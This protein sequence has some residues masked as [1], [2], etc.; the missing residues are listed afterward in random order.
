MIK[1]TKQY[2]LPSFDEVMSDEPKSK[3]KLPSFDEVMGAGEKKSKVGGNVSVA[4]SGTTAT[5]TSGGDFPLLYNRKVKTESLPATALSAHQQSNKNDTVIPKINPL[6]PLTDKDA[7]QEAFNQVN[8]AI[9]NAKTDDPLKEALES[10]G[11]D[12]GSG[13]IKIFA[14]KLKLLN[15]AFQS[16]DDSKN[17]LNKVFQIDPFNNSVDNVPIEEL[18]AMAGDNQTKQAAVKRLEQHRDVQDALHGRTLDEASLIYAA[19]SDP[20]V[21]YLLDKAGGVGGTT[22]STSA[23]PLSVRGEKKL[24]FL[25][26]PDVREMAM[27]DPDL[28]M[29]YQNEIANFPS[30]HPEFATKL[31]A[32]AIA[33]RREETGGNNWFANVVGK[34]NTDK[35]VDELIAEGQFPANYKLLY[36][37]A[38]RPKLGTA[39]AIGRGIGN[40]IPGLN[41]VV[42]EGQIPTPGLLEHFEQGAEN[43]QRGGASS[44]SH[45]L[46]ITDKL[47]PEAQQIWNT[48]EK[49]YSTPELETKNLLHKGSAAAGDLL[50]FVTGLVGGTSALNA[51]KLLNPQVA[52]ATAMVLATHGDSNERAKVLFPGE[53]LKQ[54]VYTGVMDILN[55]VMGKYLPG[56]QISRLL[57]GS[58]NVIA[59]T[60]AKMVDGKITT[61]AAKTVI[62]NLVA[63]TAKGSLKGGEFMGTIAGIDDLLTQTLQGKGIDFSQ[64]LEKGWDAFK[65]GLL[66]TGPLSAMEAGLKSNK[67]F[68]NEILSMADR[69]DYYKELANRE[70][71]TNPD[72]AKIKDDV[73]ENI[74]FVSKVKSEVIEKD[75]TDNKK[76]DYI[77]N[78]L[79]EKVKLAKAEAATDPTIK[80]QLQ[81]EAK[82]LHEIKEGALRGIDEGKIKENQAIREVKEMYNEGYL[83]KGATEMLES[84]E[85]ENGKP[86]FN[87]QKVSKFLEFVAQQTNNITEDGKFNK[88]SDARKA[89]AKQY[90]SQIIELA[91][92]MFPEYSK[93]AKEADLV[94]DI[95]LPP[96]PEGYNIVDEPVKP[97]SK[98]HVPAIE[99]DDKNNSYNIPSD[100]EIEKDLD[101]VDKETQGEYGDIV[102]AKGLLEKAL[103]AKSTG[104]SS[105][106]K[107]VINGKT[108]TIRISDHEG[109]DPDIY[110]NNPTAANIPRT[111]DMIDIILD[112]KERDY[113]DEDDFLASNNKY[114]RIHVSVPEFEDVNH[115]KRFIESVINRINEDQEFI[116]E[117]KKTNETKQTTELPKQTE[118][119]TAN[120]GTP[121][122]AIPTTGKGAREGEEMRLSHAD[123]K[124][125]YNELNLPERLETPNKKDADLIS[126]AD[127][128]VKDGYD[129]DKAAEQI[130]S[131]EK[132]SFTDEEQVAFAKVVAA[133]KAKQEGLDV[134]SP[135]F[136]VLQDKIEKYS[137]ASDVS[138]TQLGRD[139]RARQAFVPKE[140]SLSDYVM[141]EKEAAGVETLTEQQKE[142]AQKEY[143][144]ISAAKKAYEE[145][146]Q[147]LHDENARLRAEAEVKRSK[148]T[149]KKDTK[150]DYKKEREEIFTSIKDKLRAARGDTSATIVP[151]AK[152]LF[153]I[154][155]D[156]AKLVK[157]FAEQGITE[158]TQVVKNVHDILKDEINGIT[159]KDVVDLIAGEYN[160]KKKP[161]SQLAAT[162]K[163]LRDEAK[164][165]G[166][167]KALLAGEEPKNERKKI[168]RNRE[169]TELRAAIKS[170]RAMQKEGEQFHPEEKTENGK[171][172]DALK[173][174][175]EKD[176]DK[177]EEQLRTGDFSEK[178]PKPLTLDKEAKEL[179]D[180]LIKLKHERQERLLKEEYAKSSFWNKAQNE[181]ANI[182]NTPRTLMA[183]VDYSAPLRQ[184]LFATLS[185]PIIGAEAF[186]KMFKA[187]WSKKYYDRWFDNLKNS[188]NYDL[189]HDSKLAITDV[190]H[191]HLSQ[192]EEAYMSNLA[193]KIPI[194]G[195]TIKGQ[196]VG[197]DLIGRSERAYSMYL[198]KMRADLFNI[199]T[200]EMQRKGL[201]FEKNSEEFKQMAAFV[202]NITGRGDLG[203]TFNEASPILSGIFF[204]PRLMA[205]R[206][207][208][209]TYFAQPRFWKKVPPQ[210]RMDYFKG[211]VATAGI[212]LG[213]LAL[214]KA[215]GADT[216]DDP[217]SPD[218]GKIKVG[219]TRWDIWGGHQQYIRIAAQLWTNQRKSST[220]GRVTNMGDGNPYSGSRGD[221]VG[222]FFRGKLA[223]IPSVML[224]ILKGENAIGEK[225]TGSWQS[226]PG[227]IGIKENLATHLLPLVW[228]GMNEAIKDQGNK[229][230]FTV[231]VPSVFGVGTSTYKTKE[232]STSGQKQPKSNY[233][234]TSK[235]SKKAN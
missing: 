183:S 181:A 105:Y 110:I 54:G 48:L 109:Y 167:L 202:N 121:P 185:H 118:A 17:Y 79:A 126:A 140:E 63:N 106:S 117:N 198:N 173:N 75:W 152:E 227:E 196:K 95:E 18:R 119:T 33:K 148:A 58:E 113:A 155:P 212:G 133:L 139:F 180:R 49:Q 47:Q 71:E 230:W 176:I 190:D 189:M 43:V 151:Y 1:S 145:K 208:T 204:S 68:R 65:I 83:S 36:Q 146:I 3:Q 108:I 171:K 57:K 235:R 221:L 59:E 31:L 73:I 6:L 15:N 234:K 56:Q 159:E 128:L 76:K 5:S 25:M 124:E 187:S 62:T 72:F 55:G 100:K 130:M 224:D 11:V 194:L 229:A 60:L 2:R 23:I 19:Q 207:N 9:S 125:I 70:A 141:R 200:A 89:A 178:E 220:T 107:R 161:R 175:L 206:L 74:D 39:N 231:A 77:I 66:A 182:L 218:F 93:T 24:Q 51:T 81:Q 96:P 13:N 136:D 85:G 211:L 197:F 144:D 21:K 67:P 209:L 116:L 169:I 233:K 147:A 98:S 150:K 205:S 135:E 22:E 91:N 40:A 34:E 188:K 111:D 137:R 99:V 12:A 164:L 166:K 4:G 61:D 216:E 97:E 86:K 199:Y 52:Q 219:N 7:E 69:P 28:R 168:Q 165:I 46:G 82:N 101:Y 210:A 53:K 174:K 223:P 232:V 184:S 201:T 215:A 94:G 226:A 138:G 104:T 10:T 203:K 172:L 163:D 228:T 27:K 162:L 213:I 127:K 123:T 29:E 122:E 64:S 90:P 153:A 120:E 103:G 16:A 32:D 102:A 84:V 14:N 154:A 26:N 129:F 8:T 45:L 143:E 149:T 157:S 114:Q 222:G 20:Q 156:V 30:R 195:D 179:Q 131:G 41:Q 158:L 50:G 80:K 42:N 44:I 132:K 142:T 112:K 87:D 38:I 186:G 115:A 214:A 88:G 191:P 192:R 193:H 170:L 78:S 177:I 92:E 37:K 217:R 225:I 160:Q 134:K 35:I